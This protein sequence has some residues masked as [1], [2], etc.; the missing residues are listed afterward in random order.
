[1]TLNALEHPPLSA[2]RELEALIREARRRQRRRRGTVAAI[3][4]LV[5]AALLVVLGGGGRSHSPRSRGNRAAA[6]ARKVGSTA[7]PPSDAIVFAR[8]TSDG[9]DAHI[10]IADVPASGGAV[11][12]LTSV[13][14][15]GMV[16]AEPRWS[17]DG[18]RIVFVMSP[19]GDLTR[20]AGDGDIYVMNAD[21]TDMRRLTQGLDASG[22]AWSP[23]GRVIAYQ[24]GPDWSA[25]AIFTIR[26]DGTGER[27]LT[28]HEVPTGAGPAWSP[29]GSRI[30]YEWKNRVWIMNSNGT[31]AHP[32]TTCRRP[33]LS[34]SSPA[35]SPT[36]NE[37]VFLREQEHR[38]AR[39]PYVNSS[40]LYALQLSGD[41]V[42]PLT[43]R[44]RWAQSPDWRP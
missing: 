20:A 17:A 27:R 30:A 5:G 31:G 25:A 1:V 32:V 42:R 22:P 36:G 10:E 4:A 37:L 26:P 13:A 43:P 28:P 24:S 9:V 33:C 18:A 19:R 35:W 15:H 39:R 44:L 6:S 21:G 16:A 7:A 34:D 38:V 29:G 41:A 12:P 23:Q 11:V 8:A 3:L 40:R 14:K 2:E